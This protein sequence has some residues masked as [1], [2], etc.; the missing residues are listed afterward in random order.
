MPTKYTKT[1]WEWFV[2]YTVVFKKWRLKTFQ[3]L[4]VNKRVEQNIP[5]G[6]ILSDNCLAA[7]AKSEGIFTDSNS[8]I[9]FLEC[10]YGLNKHC[11]KIL[12]CL[13][14]I[15]FSTYVNQKTALKA[16]Q[17]FKKIKIIDNPA[18]TEAARITALK[19]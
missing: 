18:I 13:E 5:P 2:Y 3:Q 7:I 4:W 1:N 9:K 19:N 11:T 10:W 8:F 6:L 17:T 12:A 15:I 14:S 16:A